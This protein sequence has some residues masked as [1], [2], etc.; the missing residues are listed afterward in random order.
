MPHVEDHHGALLIVDLEQ[1]PVIANSKSPTLA[2]GQ[3]AD[4]PGSRLGS[5]GTNPISNSLVLGGR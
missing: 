4:A 5:E 3:I 1:H 2:T